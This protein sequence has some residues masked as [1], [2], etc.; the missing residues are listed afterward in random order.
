MKKFFIIMLALVLLFA[1]VSCNNEP[2]KNPTIPPA[3]G[4]IPAEPNSDTE[5]KSIGDPEKAALSKMYTKLMQVFTEL[6]G[7]DSPKDISR[8]PSAVAG[9]AF[10]ASGKITLSTASGLSATVTADEN[11]VFFLA[12]TTELYALIDVITGEG[13]IILREEGE[14]ETI[15]TIKEGEEDYEIYVNDSEEPLDDEGEE[16][17]ALMERLMAAAMELLDGLS[18]SKITIEDVVVSYEGLKVSVS[19]E[20]SLDVELNEDY[21]FED[22]SPLSLIKEGKFAIKSLSITAEYEGASCEFRIEDL[23]VSIKDIVLDEDG[24]LEACKVEL[25]IKGIKLSVGYKDE[26]TNIAIVFEA[27]NTS[28]TVA[29]APV[30]TNEDEKRIKAVMVGQT[31]IGFG[32]LVDED[33]IGLVVGV[34]VDTT[35]QTTDPMGAFEITPKAVVIN[36][37]YY[38]P[39]EFLALIM[40]M[41]GPSSLSDEP[42]LY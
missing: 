6:K 41:S 11:G 13:G 7:G 36:G 23:S 4:E 22:E 26:V 31:D 33:S 29:F 28:F 21:D 14:E 19:G 10:E 5:I 3:P 25:S 20:A 35:K 27:M 16:Y 32:L 15:L 39:D 37:Y 34:G 24:D 42:A 1:A 38:N 40:D 17:E 12:D 2:E 8:E 30:A 18:E 9:P